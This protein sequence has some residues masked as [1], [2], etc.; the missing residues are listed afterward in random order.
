LLKRSRKKKCFPG[1]WVS[2]SPFGGTNLCSFT[3]HCCPDERS[4][5]T[6]GATG[7]CYPMTTRCS[8]VGVPA[9]SIKSTAASMDKNQRQLLHPSGRILAEKKQKKMCF[10]GDWVSWSP[11]GG[12]N[13]CS[14]TEHCCP[15]ERGN[16]TKGAT[17]SCYPMTTRCSSVGTP[18]GSSANLNSSRL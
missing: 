16:R 13:L 6:K 9:S 10:P 12:T 15:D 3:E 1:D 5:R 17:G 4:N 14:F 8:T 2:W 7:S 11:F 18:A